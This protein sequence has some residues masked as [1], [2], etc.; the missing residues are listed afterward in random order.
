MEKDQRIEFA[1][2]HWNKRLKEIES[3]F[4]GMS[5]KIQEIRK[6]SL[7]TAIAM[8][9]LTVLNEAGYGKE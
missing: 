1:V 8:D 7:Y 3:E 9:L 4:Q 2:K 5:S 6:D